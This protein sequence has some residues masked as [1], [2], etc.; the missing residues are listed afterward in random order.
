MKYLLGLGFFLKE[1]YKN[2]PLVK[3]SLDSTFIDEYH[4]SE[5]VQS[6]NKWLSDPTHWVYYQ[7]TKKNWIW[8]SNN[9]SVNP[10]NPLDKTYPRLLDTNDIDFPKRFKCYII[11][12]DLL[13]CSTK[14][15]C[16]VY[17]ND[18]NY[19]NGFMTK[20]TIVDLS[21]AFLLPC[22]YVDFFKKI[23]QKNLR[24][25]FNEKIV[26]SL[27]S[28]E[29]D[30]RER[31]YQLIHTKRPN[32]TKYSEGYPFQIKCNWNKQ[33]CEFPDSIGGTG[34]LSIPLKE[35]QNGVVMFDQREQE[36]Y[37]LYNSKII[38]GFPISE[39]FFSIADKIS[40]DKY[41]YEN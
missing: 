22:R 27:Y 18:N 38:E 10:D 4:I 34:V 36:H 41:L 37:D 20:S 12:Q 30:S 31:N 3:I 7:W 11:D 24:R 13:K 5:N 39:K 28:Y 25:E 8:R 9:Q 15:I 40:I 26:P 16:K 32:D 33:E 29:G 23:E 2:E 35:N 6:S 14:L 17:N 1:K 19:T 21:K